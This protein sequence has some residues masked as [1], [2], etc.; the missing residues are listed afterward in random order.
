MPASSSSADK[1][2]LLPGFWEHL[3]SVGIPPRPARGIAEIRSVCISA[4]RF[5]LSAGLSCSICSFVKLLRSA[6]AMMPRGKSR[7]VETF[8]EINCSQRIPSLLT[9]SGAIHSSV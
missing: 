9:F 7:H 2:D 3:G 8:A 6:C 5:C 1:A 4:G